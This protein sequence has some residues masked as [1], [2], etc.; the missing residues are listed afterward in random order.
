MFPFIKKKFKFTYF[1]RYEKVV[2]KIT[3]T[4]RK[5]ERFVIEKKNKIHLVY[6]YNTISYRFGFV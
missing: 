1:I 6:T 5:I 4:E 2:T 3:T